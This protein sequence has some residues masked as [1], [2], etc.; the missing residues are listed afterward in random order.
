MDERLFRDTVGRFASGIVIV[1]GV[2]DGTPRGMTCQSFASL[3]T[4]PPQVLF[5]LARSSASW[6]GIRDSGR[7]SINVLADDQQWLSDR[8]A[9]TGA[10]KFDNVAWQPGENGAPL[11]EGCLAHIECDLRTVYDGGDHDI[12]VGS[13]RSVRSAVGSSPLLYFRGSYAGVR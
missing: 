13:V 10:D 4:E 11:F 5:C 2:H 6:R 8:F 9:R 7:F 3:S 12:A 1:T